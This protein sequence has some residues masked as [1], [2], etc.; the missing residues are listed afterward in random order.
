[1]YRYCSFKWSQTTN[2]AERGKQTLAISL[3]I[4]LN[5]GLL[6]VDRILCTRVCS[7]CNSVYI[8]TCT[9]SFAYNFLLYV[10]YAATGIVF[11][12]VHTKYFVLNINLDIHFQYNGFLYGI[13]VLSITRMFQVSFSTECVPVCKCHLNDVHVLL[14]YRENISRLLDYLHYF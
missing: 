3:L 10:K 12:I 4:L 1:M 7:T 2:H 5:M 14:T 13:L 6:V 8:S 9:G 11:A